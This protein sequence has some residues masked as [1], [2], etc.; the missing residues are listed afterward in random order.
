[1]RDSCCSDARSCAAAS[2]FGVG[3]GGGAGAGA[4]TGAALGVGAAFGAGVGSGA[5]AGDALVGIARAYPNA[6][7]TSVGSLPLKRIEKKALNARERLLNL[8]F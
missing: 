2:V 3:G 1:M 8:L 6:N 4:A 5:G 7:A